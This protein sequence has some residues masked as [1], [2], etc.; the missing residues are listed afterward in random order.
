MSRSQ[1]NALIIGSF[2]AALLLIN[3]WWKID[4]LLRPV[5]SSALG[6]EKVIL[7]STSWC[8]Y[9]AKAREFLQQANIP[10]EEKDIEASPQAAAEHRALGGIGIPLLKIR[11][12]TIDG[13]DVQ[14]IRQAI[15]SPSRESS[16]A[17]PAHSSTP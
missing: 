9:C 2:I 12:T 10:F 7:Y 1:R 17:L 15:E 6:G 11:A 8:P 13:F 3:N 16:R 5:N 14:A 4:L